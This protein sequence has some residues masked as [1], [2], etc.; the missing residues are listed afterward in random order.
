[1]SYYPNSQTDQG[2]GPI[3]A[4]N[5]AAGFKRASSREGFDRL[6]NIQVQQKEDA[7]SYKYSRQTVHKILRMSFNA[8]LDTTKDD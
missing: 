6:K 1:L 4:V 7:D 2:N 3:N 8:T 5:Q